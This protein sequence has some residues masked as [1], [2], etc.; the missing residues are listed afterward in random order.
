MHDQV[1][2][3]DVPKLGEVVA[4]LKL[5][6]QVGSSTSWSGE[7]NYV[8]WNFEIFEVSTRWEQTRFGMAK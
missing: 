1:D 3:G 8:L 5:R 7:E 6:V 4:G 2:Q